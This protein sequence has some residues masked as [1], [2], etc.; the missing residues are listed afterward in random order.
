M[1]GTRPGIFLLATAARPPVGQPRRPQTG[2]APMPCECSTFSATRICSSRLAP[3]GEPDPPLERQVL[4]VNCRPPENP[5][6]GADAPVA[7]RLALRDGVPVHAVRP[8]GR[9]R[10]DVGVEAHRSGR[11]RGVRRRRGRRNV[12]VEAHRCRRRG[13]RCRRRRRNVRVEARRRRWRV[14]SRSVRSRRRRGHIRAGAGGR[15]R[16]QR[17][18]DRSEDERLTDVIQCVPFAVR[19]RQS[20]PTGVGLGTS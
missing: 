12:G 10:R 17:S 3:F 16:H 4:G 15:K 2:Q 1:P 11:R 5:L 18:R 9:R 20:K 14:G 13:V 6:P 8:N 7:T 19:A